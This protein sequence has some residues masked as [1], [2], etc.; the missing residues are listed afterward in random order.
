MA[1]RVVFFG[2]P[3]FAAA[4]LQAL[5]ASAHEVAGVV[6]QPDRARGRGQ[7]VHYEA[8]KRL[9]LELNLP[10][11]QPERIT[12][13]A[14]L[15]ALRG[16]KPD[17][18]IVAA[19]GRLLPQ[20]LL[21][22]PRLGF[23][24]VHASLL[25]RWRGAAPVHRAILAGDSVTGITIMRVVLA[26]DAGPMLAHVSTPIAADDTSADMES[27]LAAMG[28]TLLV[29]TIDKLERGGIEDVP[30]DEAGVTYAA[31]LERADSPIQWSRPA[32]AI[33]NQIRGLQ[34]WP[35][36]ST[37]LSGRRLLLLRSAVG[38]GSDLELTAPSIQ[39]LTPVAAP[40]TVLR[41]DGDHFVVA[42]GAGAVRLLEIQPEGRRVMSARDFLNGTRVAAG[43]SLT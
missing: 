27:R 18:A 42:A 25:P 23:L 39:D 1:L 22:V 30:Q 24:N 4:S 5:A 11:W 36:A 16:V 26:L 21:D 35:L 34:P 9:A 7:K 41:A 28:G 32:L 6:S 3:A 43:D 20:T 12:D 17:L 33:H 2:T 14:F 38:R 8:T 31:K 29:E 10:L 19:F 13:P 37:T 15:N 40:G